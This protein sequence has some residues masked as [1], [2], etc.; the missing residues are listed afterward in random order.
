[1]RLILIRHG[2]SR[3]QNREIIAG[4]RSCQ[5]LTDGGVWQAQ[6]QK[7][8]SSSIWQDGEKPHKVALS[9]RACAIV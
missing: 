8:S 3:I 1:M 4:A 2:E 9:T 6:V 7:E 5:G